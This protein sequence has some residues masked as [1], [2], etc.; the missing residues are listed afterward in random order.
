[1][2]YFDAKEKLLA[3]ERVEHSTVAVEKERKRIEKEIHRFENEHQSKAIVN[4]KIGA[5]AASSVGPSLPS[6]TSGL[7]DPMT[8]VLDEVDLDALD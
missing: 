3:E 1:M 4:R 5:S 8:Q 2:W 6:P 7:L